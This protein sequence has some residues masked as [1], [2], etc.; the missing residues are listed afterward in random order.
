MSD[1]PKEQPKTTE[2]DN[3]YGRIKESPKPVQPVER[4]VP[5]DGR[6]HR[7]E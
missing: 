6:W 5:F 2:E 7:I 4:D 1:E 3:R